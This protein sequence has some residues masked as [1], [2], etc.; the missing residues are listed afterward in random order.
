V[1]LVQFFRENGARC[2]GMVAEDGHLLPVN[3]FASVYEMALASIRNGVTLASVTEGNLSG[4]RLDYDAAVKERRLLPPL[5]HPDPA[6]CIV[7]LTGLTH[8]GSAQSRDK[9]HASN[10]AARDSETDSIRMFRLGIAGGKPAPGEVGNQPEWGYKGDGRCVVAPGQP[11]TQP[12][13]AEDA[14]EEAEIAGL[15]V[16]DN[17]GNP[18]RAGFAIG[19]EFSDHVMEKR[20]YLYLAHSKLRPCSF[21]PELAL[22]PLPDSVNGTVRIVRDGHTLWSS[23]FQSGEANMC[24]SIANLEHHHFKYELFRRPGDVHVHFFGADGVSFASGLRT[25]PGDMFE[26]DVPAFGRP[27]RNPLQVETQPVPVQVRTL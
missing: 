5:D 14:G 6:R 15:Y 12:A 22:G 1:R 19:N 4:E 20:N 9:M 16:I 23:E 27:L 17:A 7:S 8:L 25:H 21:G 3:R 24:H 13:F 11:L 10:A 2:V 26:I 18:W